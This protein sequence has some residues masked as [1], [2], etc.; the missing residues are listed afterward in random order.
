[1][2]RSMDDPERD[3]GRVAQKRRSSSGVVSSPRVTLPLLASPSRE[4]FPSPPRFLS[5]SQFKLD[6]GW[7]A[8]GRD[9]CSSKGYVRQDASWWAV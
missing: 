2:R 9:R 6:N 7:L 8:W 1:M 5:L 3:T 4:T